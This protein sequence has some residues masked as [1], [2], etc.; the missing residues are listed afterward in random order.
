M[1]NKKNIKKYDY[2]GE[3]KETSISNVSNNSDQTYRFKIR[4]KSFFK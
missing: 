1:L 2:Y 4:K 3:S